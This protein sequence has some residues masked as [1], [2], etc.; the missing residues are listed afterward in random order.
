MLFDASKEHVSDA[1]EATR[2]TER[3]LGH[4]FAARLLVLGRLFLLFPWKSRSIRA[5]LGHQQ[6]Q[7]ACGRRPICIDPP[8]F[9]HAVSIQ[10]GCSLSPSSAGPP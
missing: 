3:S 7:N 10:P 8:L 6:L 1:Y 5:L 4:V 9:A 2:P